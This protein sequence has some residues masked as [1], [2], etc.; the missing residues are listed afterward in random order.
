MISLH[1]GSSA[2]ES[3]MSRSRRLA[4]PIFVT[5]LVIG[6][7]GALFALNPTA[8][9]V[10]RDALGLAFAFFTTPFI[11]ETLFA[12]LFLLGLLAINHWR[13]HREGD[14]WVWLMTQESENKNLPPTI[15]QRLQSTVLT[16]KPDVPDPEQTAASVI[17]GY[18]ELGMSAQ[19]L[20]E[21]GE[22]PAPGDPPSALALHVRVLAAN[23][24]TDTATALL[25]QTAQ[26]RQ[27]CRKEMV[28]ACLESARWLLQHMHR[29]D[30]ARH[31]MQQAVQLDPAASG[32]AGLDEALKKLL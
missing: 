4:V 23:L 32:F 16:E 1:P 5:V 29:E 20:Q 27:E 22:P 24:D 2:L 7:L 19:A 18:L 12:L 30:L 10:T 14:G 26:A 21:L 9:E 15:T 25:R 31:W 13:L 11:F 3:Y 28:A 8:W 6:A 17:E